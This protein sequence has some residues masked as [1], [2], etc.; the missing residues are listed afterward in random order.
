MPAAPFL[1]S[2]YAIVWLIAMFY[3]WT[4]W[5][6][7]NTLEA[8]IPHAR[9]AQQRKEQEAVTS[10]GHFIFIPSVLFVGVVIG[11]ILG[12]ARPAMRTTW[13]CGSARKSSEGG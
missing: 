12:R 3:I 5:Q 13:N 2:A 1:I 11:W 6:R 8:G 10:P 4:I 7:V 9:A